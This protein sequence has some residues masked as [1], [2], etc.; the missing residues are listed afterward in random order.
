[1]ITCKW[2]RRGEEVQMLYVHTDD[3]VPEQLAYAFDEMHVPAGTK[4]CY[5]TPEEMEFILSY[6]RHMFNKRAAERTLRWGHC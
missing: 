4:I 6:Q 2:Q 3:D 1:M 5:N